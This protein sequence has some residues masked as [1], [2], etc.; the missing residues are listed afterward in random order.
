MTDLSLAQQ[1][2]ALNSKDADHIGKLVDVLIA[3]SRA[4][5]ASDIHLTPSETSLGV[6]LRV[7]GVLQQVHDFERDFGPKLI[8][9]L[10]VLASLLTYRTDIPQE[11]RLGAAPASTAEASS[12]WFR[13]RPA[14]ESAKSGPSA[15][16][17]E[18]EA[19]IRLS[20]FPT[21]FGEKAVLRMFADTGHF[22]RIS[23][24][25]LPAEVEQLLTDDLR[26]TSG[27]VLIAGPA[28][29]GKTT[30]AYACL[31]E[32]R[33]T[34]RG[35][36][37]LASLE[38]PVEVVVPGVAQTQVSEASG[39]DMNLGLRSLVRQDPEVILVG[40]IRDSQ[41]AATVFQAALT[42]HLILSTIHASSAAE[43]LSRL[44][45]M[46]IE[47]YVLRSGIRSIIGQ[48]LLRRRCECGATPGQSPEN[49]C[50][51]C[52]GSG[53]A[54]R[55]V[56][57]EYLSPAADMIGRVLTENPDTRRI[58]AAATEAG[59]TPLRTQA[60]RAVK[61]GVTTDNELIRVF[62]MKHE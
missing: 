42:G 54:G 19:A 52:L 37:S 12:S 46:G 10:K 14:S 31:R 27:L 41:T 3:H 59:M 24:L 21:I 9:R 35:N 38:D 25:S 26:Q 34:S 30:S 16:S 15:S 7:D 57:A 44:A 32:V 56:L 53:Y 55:F 23:D 61:Q 28:G 50:T 13:R 4:A 18:A 48:R 45:D 33:E 17:T 8:A 49:A 5:R 40:E 43:A 1:I 2:A 20:V 11:G 22:E 36:R 47:Q 6:Q 51:A 39:L 60:K 62:G 58:Q 29:A